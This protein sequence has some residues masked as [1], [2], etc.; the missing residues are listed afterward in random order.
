MAITHAEHRRVRPLYLI[1]VEHGGALSH[2]G[3]FEAETDEAGSRLVERVRADEALVKGTAIIGWG[4][5]IYRLWKL[6]GST[7]MED[8]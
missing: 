8:L 5:P 7:Y 4:A 6:Q 2:I 3:P 1:T